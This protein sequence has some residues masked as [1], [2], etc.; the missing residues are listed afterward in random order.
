[1]LMCSYTDSV[2]PHQVGSFYQANPPRRTAVCSL[3]EWGE[4]SLP[5]LHSTDRSA[6]SDTKAPCYSTAYCPFTHA[7]AHAHAHTYTHTLMQVLR[8]HAYFQ[9]SVHERAEEQFRVRRCTIYFYLED[10]TIQVNESQQVN[11]GIPQGECTCV[12]LRVIGC[13]FGLYIVK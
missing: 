2:C 9:E 8:F 4:I 7:H 6:L 3:R 1:M 10:D 13:T 12:P 5:G 11:S